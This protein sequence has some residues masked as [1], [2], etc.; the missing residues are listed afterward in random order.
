[1]ILN[2][3]DVP[4]GTVRW[5]DGGP[6]DAPISAMW[7]HGTPNVGEPPVPLLE[8]SAARGIRWLGFDRPDYGGS[9]AVDGRGVSDAADLAAR[10]ADAAGVDTFAAVG[11]S[12]GGPHALACAALLGDRVTSVV[13]ISGLA[14]FDAKGLDWFAGMHP[15]GAKELRAAMHGPSN[16]HTLLAASE[17]D[18]EMFTPADTLALAGEWS[19]FNG[20]AAEGV[21]R[22]LG[23]MTA[24]DVAY[25]KEW[26]FSLDTIASPALFVHGTD[27]RIVPL[28]HGR[29]NAVATPGAVLWERPG[30]GHISVMSAGVEILDWLVGTLA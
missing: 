7:H 30:D 9:T 26:G 13:S 8:A 15:G 16:L 24:D 18:P 29:W 1:M 17:F 12:G 19:W 6:A 28:S 11:H 3:L 14:P 25:V 22:G 23:S 10:V 4:N 27:D 5:Y 21:S 20:I 2:L